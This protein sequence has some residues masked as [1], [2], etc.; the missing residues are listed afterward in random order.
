MSKKI[1]FYQNVIINTRTN[2]NYEIIFEDDFTVYANDDT[3]NRIG[4][5]MM[6][7]KEIVSIFD[8]NE[9]IINKPWIKTQE[10]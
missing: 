5:D 6:A 8:E 4:I 3:G 1:I 10:I 7:D 9:N 2:I